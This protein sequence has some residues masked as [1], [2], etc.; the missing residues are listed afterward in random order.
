MK[1]IQEFVDI[2]D[3]KVIKEDCANGGCKSEKNIFLEGPFLQA[4]SKNKNKRIYRKELCDREVKRLNEEKISK[5]RALGE[6]D[7]PSSPQIN[8]DRVSHKIDVL[9]MKGNT[10]YGKAKLLNTPMGKI[11]KTLVEEGIILGMSTRAVGTIDEATGYVN[12]DLQL[13]TVDI[14]SDPSVPKAFVDAVMEGKEWIMEGDRFI[15]MAINNMEKKLS[16]EG[17]KA[18]YN[19]MMGF[20]TEIRG[21]I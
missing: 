11:A 15:E 6:L 9:E 10:G 2:A 17:S 1:L 21:R 7:H 18:A 19:A 8:L 13:I 3:L 14:V 12:D 16:N 20:L 5:N 4:E